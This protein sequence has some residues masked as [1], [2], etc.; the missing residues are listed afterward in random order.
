MLA[1]S[2]LVFS[3]TFLSQ[4]NIIKTLSLIK[5]FLFN[6]VFALLAQLCVFLNLKFNF[7]LFSIIIEHLSNLSQ[8]IAI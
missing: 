1:R 3:A 7:N 8:I 5:M 4:D 2:Q 6:T